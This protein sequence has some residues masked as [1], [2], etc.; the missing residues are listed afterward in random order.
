MNAGRLNTLQARNAEPRGGQG[1][2]ALSFNQ[3]PLGAAR[4]RKHPNSFSHSSWGLSRRDV[5][6]SHLSSR[7]NPP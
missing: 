6:C 4:K 2:G 1:L 7:G 5:P 3:R